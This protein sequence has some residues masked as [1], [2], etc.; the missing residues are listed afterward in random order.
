MR[1]P[2]FSGLI[3]AVILVAMLT[4][5]ESLPQVGFKVSDVVVH[6]LV[7][8][9]WGFVVRRETTLSPFAVVAAGLVLIFGT[10]LLQ[11]LIPGRMFSWWDILSDALGLLAGM[12]LAA[13]WA[14]RTG[15][16]SSANS[17]R[18]AGESQA[19]AN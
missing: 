12:A 7:F 15:Q 4:P 5:A 6:V 11:I 13:W 1:V 18:A 17:A 8:G 19:R 9:L 16:D 10:E 14:A 2:W 3:T